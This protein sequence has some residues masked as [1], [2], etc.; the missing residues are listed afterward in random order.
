M[1]L[2][3]DIPLTC[4][5]V[6]HLKN[7]FEKWEEFLVGFS[8]GPLVGLTIGTIEVSLAGL[9]LGLPFGSPFDSKN[10]GLTGIILGIYLGNPLGYLIGSIWNIN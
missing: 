9:S 3:L 2:H 6:W 10:P 8:P 1:D 4:C 5:L 7:S